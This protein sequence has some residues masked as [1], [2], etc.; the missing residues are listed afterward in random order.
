MESP[1]PNTTVPYVLDN[2]SSQRE[3]D[4]AVLS[5]LF[6]LQNPRAPRCSNKKKKPGAKCL[7]VASLAAK[8]AFASF[9]QSDSVLAVYLRYFGRMV[10][11]VVRYVVASG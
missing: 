1:R 4:R 7:C 10:K 8:A 11:E 2:R 5:F 6:R 3:A 9:K